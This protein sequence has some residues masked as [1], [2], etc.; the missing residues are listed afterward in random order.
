MNAQY[1]SH[2]RIADRAALYEGVHRVLAPG[3]RFAI[4]DVIAGDA[5][6]IEYPVPWAMATLRTDRQPPYRVQYRRNVYA[7]IAGVESQRKMPSCRNSH[8]KP[9]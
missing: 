1:G 9:A 2:S 6:P 4:Y 7:L 3:G 5:G 8:R